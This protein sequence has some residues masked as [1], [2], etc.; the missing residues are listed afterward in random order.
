MNA[1]QLPVGMPPTS[2]KPDAAPILRI[3]AVMLGERINASN[4]DIGTLVSSTPAAFRVHAGLAVVF[5]YGVV[6]LIGLLPSEEKVVLDSLKSRVTGEFSPFE[7]EIAQA[8]LCPDE[9]AEVIQPG[10]P[11]CLSK[12]SDERLLLIADALAKSTSLAR[13]ERRVAAVFDVIEPLARELAEQ[14]RTSRRR[15]GILQLIG[16]ALLVQ[17]RVA[18]RVAVAEKPDVLWE[19]PQLDRLYARLEDEYELTERLDTLERKLKVISETA[20]ALTDIIDTQRSLRLEIAV[21]VLIV[22]EVA[23]GCFQ[24]F[25]GIH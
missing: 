7:E 9:N 25:A 16:N 5:R 22:I 21:V 15:K 12:F 4:L 23:I 24:I 19:K 20:D 3:R 8:Q 11:I 2:Q 18:G 17:Q 10:G 13:D 14:G 6:V 1:D